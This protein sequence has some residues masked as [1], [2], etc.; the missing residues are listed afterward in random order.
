M[1]KKKLRNILIGVASVIVVLLAAIAL[2][3][4]PLAKHY[5]E[6]HSKELIGRRITLDKIRLNP[7]NGKVGLDNFVLYEADD[8][9]HFASLDRFRADIKL[10]ALLRRHIDISYITFD[11]PTLEVLQEGSHF[12]FDDMVAHLKGDTTQVETPKAEKSSWIVEI[13]S[14]TFNR[15]RVRYEDRI[16]EAT[17]G[18]NDLNLYIPG[19]YFSGEDTDVGME[20]EFAEGGRLATS[21]AY[22]MESEQFDLSVEI[23]SMIMSSVLPYFRQSFNVSRVGGALTADVNLRGNLRHVMAFSIIGTADLDGFSMHDEKEREVLSLNHAHIQVDSIDF[24]NNAFR[25]GKLHANGLKSHY[26]IYA[27]S[28]TNFTGLLKEVSERGQEEDAAVAVTVD[29]TKQSQP[30]KLQVGELLLSKSSLTFAD[31]TLHRPF[32]YALTDVAIRGRDL[33]LDGMNTLSASATLQNTGAARIK[34]IGSFKSIANQNITL[35]LSNVALTDFTTYSEAF[36]A[37][38]ITAGNLTFES[39]NVITDYELQGTNHLDTYR[40]AVDKKLKEIKPTLKLPLKLGVY[41][42]TDKQGH[43]N[44]DLPVK[45]RIDDPEFSYRK[46]VFKALGNVLLKVATAPFSFL[47]GKKEDFSSI[48]LSEPLRPQFN[49]EQYA[50]LDDI[51][52]TLKEKPEMQVTLRQE[53]NFNDA[54]QQMSLYSLKADYYKHQTN[55]TTRMELLDYERI[56]AIKEN[57]KGLET[58]ADEALQRKGL[59]SGKKIGDKAHTLYGNRSEVQTEQLLR[60]RDKMV[61]NYMLTKQQVK[62]E[63]FS[64]ASLS[65]EKL[66]EYRGKNRYSIDMALEG[67]TVTLTEAEPTTEPTE[68]ETPETAPEAEQTAPTE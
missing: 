60:M 22:N 34:W 2:G 48:E 42:L 24:I 28:T 8:Q 44:L 20:F 10:W 12:N 25:F 51:A 39:Q 29:S 13:D 11:S 19:I 1:N 9:H 6:K 47:R 31:N 67:E 35:N 7:L 14:I 30:L 3:A 46:I 32:S 62:A 61:L 59:S 43:I 63:Q 16:V 23:D 55:D 21:L 41:V 68:A 4:G 36:T 53:V 52:A 64:V 37:H 38:P 58:F 5:L 40:L 45:G 17:W 54:V 33:D 57:D 50:I 66:R 27:D 65:V 15:G 18:F 56:A 26:E 49:S